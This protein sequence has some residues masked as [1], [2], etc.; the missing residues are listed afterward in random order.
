MGFWSR[1]AGLWVARR[2]AVPIAL[3]LRPCAAVHTLGMRRS[4]DVVFVADDGTVLRTVPRLAPWRIA[5]LPRRHGDLG[6]AGGRLRGLGVRPGRRLRVAASC[7]GAANAE[8]LAP[9][10]VDDAALRGVALVEFLLAGLLVLLPL[11]F[12]VLELAQLMVARNALN[13]ATFE[14]ARVG[15]VTRRESRRHAP[16]A[17]ARASCRCSRR[18][19]RSPCLRGAPDAA[20]AGPGAAGRARWRARRWKCSAPT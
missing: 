12:A 13:Y 19:I 9:G 16:R 1:A 17:G 11:T 10:C 14:A 18:S 5:R 6:T 7:A 2:A 3:E 4:I 15:S 8:P 20:P